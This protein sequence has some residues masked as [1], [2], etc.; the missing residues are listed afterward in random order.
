MDQSRCDA[1]RIGVKRACYNMDA[2]VSRRAPT[3]QNLKYCDRRRN[4]GIQRIC[5][6]CHWDRNPHIAALSHQSP[7]PRF[8]SDDEHE[9]RLHVPLEEIDSVPRNQPS[10]PKSLPSQPLDGSSYVRDAAYRHPR[11][12]PSGNSLDRRSDGHSAILRKQYRVGAAGLRRPQES[13]QIVRVVQLIRE[14][15]EAR[16]TGNQR[17]HLDVRK[18][19]R[20]G[21]NALVLH[22]PNQLLQLLAAASLNRDPELCSPVDDCCDPLAALAADMNLAKLR[23]RRLK[24]SRDRMHPVNGSHVRGSGS[25]RVYNTPSFH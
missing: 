10:R 4:R 17:L 2:V 3:S 20:D 1:G 22:I 6:A 8:S 15:Q 16:L 24:P 5:P 23:R 13:T 7:D 25:D 19:C 11:R 14:H 9:G 18:G 21:R 12:R